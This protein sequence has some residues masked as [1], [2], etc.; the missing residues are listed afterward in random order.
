MI[1]TEITIQELVNR[2]YLLKSGNEAINNCSINIEADTE[3]STIVQGDITNLIQVINNLIINAVQ[4]YEDKKTNN[5]EVAISI[6]KD[7][8]SIKLA[9]RDYGKGISDDIKSRIFKSMV[10][11]KGKYGTGL[12]LLL[13]YATIKGKFGWEIWFE[14][15]ENVGTA[16]YITIPLHSQE[17]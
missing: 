2:I 9:I 11:S 5:A 17:E 6:C 16:F 4:S 14:T 3:L 1:S 8:Y 12:S 15:S 7:K 10:T 13:S